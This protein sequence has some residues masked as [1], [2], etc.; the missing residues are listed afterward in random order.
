MMPVVARSAPALAWAPVM[1]VPVAA[2]SLARR[3]HGRATGVKASANAEAQATVLADPHMAT[4]V[5][6]PVTPAATPAAMT[7]PGLNDD[8][9]FQQHWSV[10]MWRDFKASD[11]FPEGGN[12]SL[13]GRLGEAARSLREGVTATGALKN[14]D[15]ARYWAYHVS[16]TSFFLLQAIVGLF[17]A[18]SGGSAGS[19]SATPTKLET[20][21]TG[22][23]GPLAEV[24][25]MYYQDLQNIKEG[26]YGFP[27]D[28]E[29]VRHRQ[30]NPLFVLQRA[31]AFMGEA[32]LTMQRKNAQQ[33]D[34]VWLKSGLLPQYYQNT[35]HYQTDGW[36]S[37]D[38]AKIYETSTETLFL[39]RQDAMQRCTLVPLHD[40]LQGRD[41]AQLRALEVA[42]G[43][44][45]FATYVKDNWPTLPL[46][47]SDLSP[48]YLAE[49]RSNAKHWHQLR[50]GGA[51]LGGAEGTGCD[52]LQTPA[53]KIDAPDASF[54]IVYSIYLFHELPPAILR[55]AVR[56][57]ARVVKPG[58]L[59]V[60]TDSQQL[61]DRSVFNSEMHKF[62]DFNEPYYRAYIQTDLGQLFE[63][64]GLTC[65]TKVQGSSTKTLSF[66]KPTVPATEGRAILERSFSMDSMDEE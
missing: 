12:S 51:W 36:L 15:H 32:R 20:I 54:D 48:Y 24:L 39:G 62:G 59:V 33:P 5:T 13:T 52:F 64:A 53:E 25:L 46:T 2:R 37:A 44:G 66:R 61:G 49:A 42:A 14:I 4:S 30:F 7:Y 45:R 60:L 55:A 41:P 35:F 47:V 31:A 57:M 23:R 19:A 56:E 34:S 63:E 40:Y 29:T 28:M 3:A 18:Q 9:R 11:L 65:D 26:K 6:T 38:S 22:A 43:T 58:G 21:V 10:A 8:L 27:W 16:R 50:A 17:I 1:Q